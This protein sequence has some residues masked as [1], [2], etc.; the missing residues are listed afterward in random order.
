M[1]EIIYEPHPVTAERKKEL[2]AKGYKIIDAIFA[3][4]DYAHPE[5]KPD[6]AKKRPTAQATKQAE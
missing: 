6:T 5:Q 4:D 2:I 1:K 3:P